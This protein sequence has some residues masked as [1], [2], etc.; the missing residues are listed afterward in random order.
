M[1][2]LGVLRDGPLERLWWKEGAK[3]KKKHSRKGKL[4]EKKIHVR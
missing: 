2:D 3:Y 4:K 1:H